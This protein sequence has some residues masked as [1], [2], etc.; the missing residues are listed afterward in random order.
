MSLH[1]GWWPC[2]PFHCFIKWVGGG[3]GRRGHGGESQLSVGTATLEKRGESKVEQNQC[4]SADQP[5]TVLL[6]LTSSKRVVL[7][8]FAYSSLLE[9][10]QL[11]FKVTSVKQLKRKVVQHSKFR[12]PVWTLHDCLGH[13][14]FFV[15]FFDSHENV[16]RCNDQC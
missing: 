14:F 7:L 16:N 13:G 1:G 8:S 3:G 2:E 15:F 11:G 6:G 9:W 4:P 5:N 10:P 12:V